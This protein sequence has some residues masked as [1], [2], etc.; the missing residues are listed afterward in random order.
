MFFQ[1]SFQTTNP[2]PPITIS[3]D[4]VNNIVELLESKIRLWNVS[5]SV[6]K[7]SNPALQKDDTEWNILFQMLSFRSNKGKNSLKSISAPMNS[8]AKVAINI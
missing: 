5:V 2:N 8:K 6:L 1:I 4:N 7:M 3:P